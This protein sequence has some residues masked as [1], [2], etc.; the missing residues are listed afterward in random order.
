MNWIRSDQATRSRETNKGGC[1]GYVDDGMF[2]I[3]G[4]EMGDHDN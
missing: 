4:E 1:G 2:I 3:K